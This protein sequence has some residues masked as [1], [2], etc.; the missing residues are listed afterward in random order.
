ML[1]RKAG[2]AKNAFTIAVAIAALVPIIW[3]VA[4]A[5]PRM[6][7]P[8]EL[9]WM[10]GGVL[11]HVRVILSGGPLYREPSID[12][13]PFIYSPFYYYA[14]AAV[15]KV[16]GLGFF[17]PRLLSFVSILGCFGLIGLW[18]HR[19]TGDVAS[20]FASAGL[21]AATY[22]ASGYWFELARVDSLFLLL[23][24]SGYVCARFGTSTR[25]TVAAGLLL[26][27]AVLSKQV[28][29]V[30]ALPALAYVG[31]CSRRRGAVMAGTF[32]GVLAVLFAWLQHSSQGW[33]A[34]YV[35]RVPS[36]H[37]I[38]WQDWKSVLIQSFW[39]SLTPMVLAAAAVLTG[40]GGFWRRSV[41]LLHAG[42]LL[43][44]FATSY[45]SILHTGGYAN[46]LMPVHAAL[47]I[48]SG[49]VFKRLRSLWWE[50]L[51]GADAFALAAL[52][53]QLAALLGNASPGAPPSAADTR[54][55][56]HML[57]VLRA[58]PGPVWMISSGFYAF[59]ANGNPVT[60]HAMALAD[61]FK[62]DSE[63]I[64]ARLLAHLFD[65]IRAKRFATIVID[66]KGGFLPGNIVDEVKRNYR[67]STR[68]FDDPG[69]FFPKVGASVRPE[70]IW[71]R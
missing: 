21:F 10:E 8:F 70:E 62:S 39:S 6:R 23:V 24:L 29:L 47:A 69:V 9:E 60:A 20:G 49:I 15:C 4:T 31:L 63:P 41:W 46:V 34:F 26:A 48:E 71:V 66:N 57:S 22:G 30:L 1:R 35:F 56:E 59:R 44:A 51:R 36:Q 68:L 2:L 52:G 38:I 55:G 32:G 67:L 54:A 65:E 64:K 33:F 3:F 16:F 42:W 27:L 12:F 14:T 50:R 18:V 45:S 58:S 43:A 61:V 5:L 17:A 28:G 13:T 7:Y 25:A 37:Q 19:E 11:D 53:L 40:A